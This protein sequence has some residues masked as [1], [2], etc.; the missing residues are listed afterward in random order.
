LLTCLL[1]SL[2]T[3]PCAAI[4]MPVASLTV[5]LTERKR[6]PPDTDPS[7]CCDERWT[8]RAQAKRRHHGT[9][10]NLNGIQEVVSSILIGST[11]RHLGKARYLRISGLLSFSG[12]PLRPC[13]T[14]MSLE[15]DRRQEH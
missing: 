11:F 1:R 5:I 3:H 2:A 9:T 14:P 6:P 4:L 8:I 10:T 13:G 12:A 15:S 7:L